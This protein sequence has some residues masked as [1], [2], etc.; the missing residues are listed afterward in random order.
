MTT[1]KCK[2][3]VE[4]IEEL[5]SWREHHT[6]WSKDVLVGRW[7]GHVSKILDEAIKGLK[8]TREEI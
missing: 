3:M 7:H 6:G 8:K 2:S 1:T 4:L 5:E